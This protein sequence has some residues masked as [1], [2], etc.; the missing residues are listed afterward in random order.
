MSG[1]KLDSPKRQALLTMT[2]NG[3]GV[4]QAGGRL[5]VD[6]GPDN[7][8]LRKH[9][10]VQAMLAVTDLFYLAEPMV[11]SL[12]KED[13]ES[14]LDLNDIRYTPQPKFTGKSGY[15]HLFDF[16]IPKS[17]RQPERILKAINHPG[18]DTAEAV[19]FAWLDTKDVRAP[20]SR[21]YAVLN[22]GD[23]KVSSPPLEALRR[24]GVTPVLWSQ[25]KGVR[26]ELQ[27]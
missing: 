20:E 5:E 3:F 2:L 27:A 25:R 7:F 18:R 26:E 17:R 23:H 10:L 14:W 11:A 9:N 4:R 24:Y 19:A 21:I 1:C 12:F 8:A 15:D 16:V 22:D 6:A 13:V